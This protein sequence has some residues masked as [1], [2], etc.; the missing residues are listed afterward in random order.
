MHL[1]LKSIEV[2]YETVQFISITS[3]HER[4]GTYW[5]LV[6]VYILVLCIELLRQQEQQLACPAI[7]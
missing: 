5:F 7:V 1:K 4:Q 6:Y 2:P 3:L